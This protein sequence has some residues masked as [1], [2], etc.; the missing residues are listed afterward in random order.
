ML[1]KIYHLYERSKNPNLSTKAVPTVLTMA[2][3]K[4]N[5]HL[6]PVELDTSKNRAVVISKINDVSIQD[7]PL[8]VDAYPDS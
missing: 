6:P 3:V 4:L 8:K 2:S 1:Q 5:G 7:W